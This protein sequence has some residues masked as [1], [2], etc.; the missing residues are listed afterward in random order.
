M[1][2]LFSNDFAPLRS[3]RDFGLRI[4][5]RAPALKRAFMAEAAGAGPRASR[6][7]RGLGL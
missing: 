1:L 2:R 5:D 7:S 6:L 3:L 4:V